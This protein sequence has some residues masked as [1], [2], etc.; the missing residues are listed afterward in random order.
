VNLV[1]RLQHPTRQSQ[2]AAGPRII[3]KYQLLEEVGHGSV[4]VVY[5]A[6]DHLTDEEVAVKVFEPPSAAQRDI[7]KR[8]FFNEVRANGLLH[9]PNIV[10]VLDAGQEGDR[11]YVVMEY[12]PGARTL[13]DVRNER[14]SLPVERVI[15]IGVDCAEALHY[16]HGKG[17]IHRDIKPA[18]VLIEQSGG[19]RLSDFGIAVLGEGDL[20]ET[21]TFASAGSPLYM[22][23][24]QVR[25]DAVTPSTDLFA[26][27]VVMY[28]L[29]SGQH[30][31]RGTSIAAVTA[32]LLDHDPVPLSSLREG[33]PSGLSELVNATLAKTALERPSSGLELAR[34]LSN[35]LGG[36][37]RPLEGR[38][39]EGRV[40]QLR[41]LD[42]FRGFG[43]AELWELLRWAHWEE[44]ECGD[45]VVREGEEGSSFFILVEGAMDVRKF[46]VHLSQLEAGA[47]FGEISYLS[48][49]PRSASVI[50]VS[51]CSVLR[52]T[53]Q[54]LEG[55]S[56]RCQLAFQNV[57]IRT[58]ISR[59]VAT[60]SALTE[61]RG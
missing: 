4:G 25:H 2:R 51:S 20:A 35:L 48:S 3:G 56:E 39:A 38:I 42:F 28:E 53:A 16:A 12:V 13:E 54:L 34:Q 21:S 31:F 33:L 36:Q 19:A 5:R 55:A 26:L 57:F 43:N 61:D 30:P 59:L 58:L 10:P 46:D 50:A 37:R 7:Y 1:P 44:V 17:V 47:C 22:A 60:T 24:E 14:L 27:G 41:E 45:V 8:L 18:N 49:Q 6:R 11:Y 40:D 29:L 52:V 9:H 23:P 32:R 15:E